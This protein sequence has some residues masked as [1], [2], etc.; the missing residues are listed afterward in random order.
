MC[1][2]P[3]LLEPVLSH[4]VT[5]PFRVLFIGYVWPEP[6]S[7]AAGSHTLQLIEACQ[8]QDWR[9]TFA[10]PAA[11]GEQRADL[12]ALGV[13]EQAI[14]L[15]CASFDAWVAGLQPDI[16]VFDRYMMEEQ[17]GWR[18]EQHCP[19]ALRVLATSDLHSL[20][21]VRQRRAK[22]IPADLLC[23]P[24][25][26]ADIAHDMAAEQLTLRELSALYRSDLTLVISRAEYTLLTQQLGVPEQLLVYLP[27]MLPAAPSPESRPGFAARRDF[28]TIGNYRHAPNWDAVRMLREHLWPRLRARVPEARLLV[29]GAYTPPKATALHQP[30]SGFHVMGWAEDALAVLTQA[31]VCLAPLRFGAGLKGKLVDAMQA[32]T[33]SVTTSVGAE[34]LRPPGQPWCGAVEDTH[35]GFVEA[36]AMLYQDDTAWCTA[37]AQGYALLASE[38]NAREHAEHFVGRCRDCLA[39]LATHR[40][41]NLTG[42][43]L[44]HHLHKSTQYMA[45]WIAAKNARTEGIEDQS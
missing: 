29:Y 14:A 1:A 17:F 26:P 45:L 34:G 44:R 19:N 35:K 32:G 37:Q 28:I 39:S 30:A 5:P 40:L 4:P 7:S 25:A 20:R 21:D 36:A 27:F 2:L 42:A 12:T 23:V 15:N 24:E 3:C 16:V 43:M 22:R 6:R 38:F 31:R 33:P 8:A 9:V 13:D 18:V 11:P 10:S 41:S